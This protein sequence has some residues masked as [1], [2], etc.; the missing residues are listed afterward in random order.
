MFIS[1]I[2]RIEIRTT[3]KDLIVDEAPKA[4]HVQAFDA[5]GKTKEKGRILSIYAWIGLENM[6]TALSNHP[7]V[8]NLVS[9]DGKDDPSIYV[10]LVY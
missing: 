2:K 5:K 9:F 1:D 6:F 3:S 4:L 8:W 10:R 7:F